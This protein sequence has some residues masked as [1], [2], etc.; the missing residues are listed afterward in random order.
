MKLILLL[1]IVGTVIGINL[2]NTKADLLESGTHVFEDDDLT[3]YINIYYDGKDVE[4]IESSDT[5]TADINSGYIYVEDK[6]PE[7]L[8]FNGFVETEDRTIGAV[9]RSDGTSCLGYVVDGVDGLKYDESTHTV[10]FTVKNLQAGCMLTV[11]V[12]TKTPTLADGIDRMDFYNT[13]Q[14]TEGL[15]TVVSN[16]VHA[17]IG[18]EDTEEATKYKVVYQYTGIVPSTATPVPSTKEYVGNSIVGLEADATAVGYTF[19]GWTTSDVTVSN[20]TFTMPTTTVTFTGSFTANPTY[21]LSYEIS[22]TTPEGYVVPSAKAYYEG[23]MVTLDS[24]KVGDVI[25]GYKFLGWTA[26]EVTIN[27]E[28]SFEMPAKNVVITGSFEQVKYNVSYQFLGDNVPSNADSLL[29]STNSYV[30]G[31][32]VTLEANPSASGYRF[33][34]WYKEATF[35]MPEEDVVIYGEWALESGTFEPTVTYEVVNEKDYYKPG[36]TIKY[37]VT[38]TNTAGYAITDVMV[39]EKNEKLKFVNGEGY[40]VETDRIAKI[41]SIGANSSVDLYLEYKVGTSDS[42]TVRSEV[43]I[44]GAL[45]SGNY[46]LNTE[47]TYKATE[48]ISILSKL[49]VCNTVSEGSNAKVFI[50]H[51]TSSGYDSWMVLEKNECKTIYVE[52]GNYK[53]LEVVPQDYELESVYGDLTENNGTL[54]VE[55]GTNYEVT[56]NN[57]YD[58]KGFFHTFGRMINLITNPAKTYAK[59]EEVTINGELF[60]VISDNGSTVTLFA[61]YNLGTDYKQNQAENDIEFVA[62]NVSAGEELDIQTGDNDVKTYVN[63]YVTYLQGETG[64][65]SISGGLIT[66]AQLET[67]G[68]DVSSSYTCADSEYADWLINGQWIWIGNAYSNAYA[69]SM[70]DGGRLTNGGFYD[71][72]NGVRPVITIS[73]SALA[74]YN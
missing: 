70:V 63:E 16:T 44:I 32:T 2:K 48:S 17:W 40:T 61:R 29:P 33:L 53:I 15:M 1:I 28:N 35:I 23:M 42:G 34:G 56:F 38:V 46:T 43:E 22:G 5:V 65:S 26:S 45:A 39:E 74:K 66:F 62:S 12:K 10:T 73:K 52:P 58:K 36:E 20:N 57:V 4:G 6:I 37:K 25:N 55:N 59:G 9:K 18:S 27:D 54:S 49:K 24:L 30:P 50:F 72:G 31:S 51:I 69:Y 7:G 71:G 14:A 21:M 8:I 64:D 19:S 47:K 11:G 3:Y 67:L 13:A 68:C 41:A 60:N